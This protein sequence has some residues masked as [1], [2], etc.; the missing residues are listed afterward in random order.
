[1]PFDAFARRYTSTGQPLGR[2]FRVNTHTTGDQWVTA[3]ASDASGNFVVVWYGQGP[4]D[5]VGAFGQRYADTGAPL[6]PE[7]RV[8][9]YT[10]NHQQAP[11]MGSDASGNF[12]VVWTSW[13]QDGS[14]R[15]VFGQRYASTGAPLGPEFRVNTY[16]T[17]RQYSPAVASDTSGNFVVV[18]TSSEQDG[19]DRG[20]FGQ[21]Y[22]STGAPLGPEFRVNTYTTDSQRTPT[23]VSDSSGNFVVVWESWGE[24]GSDGGVFG[25]RYADT[26]APLGPEFRVNT[27]TTNYQRFPAVASDGGGSSGKFVIAWQSRDQDGFDEGVFAQRY[28]SIVPVELTGFKVE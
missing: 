13:D 12:V 25:Q 6:G 16:T 9:T 2:Q 19:S 4:G 26:G 21:R 7:F 18:W 14:D 3:V 11:A 22:A 23:V 27:Y 8:N 17:N 24:D 15:G 28:G 20:V 5:S 10:R 1:V